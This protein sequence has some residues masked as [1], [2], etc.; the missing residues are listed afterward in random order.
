MS[1]PGFTAERTMHA[2]SGHFH[3]GAP[4][5][6]VSGEQMI[7]MAQSPS[8]PPGCEPI[9]DTDCCTNRYSAGLVWRYC[10]DWCKTR[11]GQWRQSK[12]RYSCRL[13]RNMSYPQ[14]CSRTP[15]FPSESLHPRTVV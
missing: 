12:A 4:E 5:D 1:Q 6:T 11:G 14:H 8:C 15:G 3:M 9:P 10:T 2:L 13:I 7:T